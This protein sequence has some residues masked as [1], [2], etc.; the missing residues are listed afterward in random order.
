MK[1]KE[2]AASAAW[3]K[4]SFLP[5][6]RFGAT[7]NFLRRCLF[8]V[9][10]I[11]LL[12]GACGAAS[13]QSTVLRGD[14][15]DPSGAVIPGATMSLTTTDGHTVATATSDASG[16]F[17]VSNLAPG[18]YIVLANAK[19]FA[20]SAFGPSRSP[21]AKAGC[22]TSRS[23]SQSRSSRS[24]SMRTHRPSAS[25]PPATPTVSSSKAKTSTRF[26]MILTGSR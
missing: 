14:V 17:S 20:P 10:G 9:L 24:S 26:P 3:G 16:V 11:A 13:A 25:I 18:T 12:A 8:P 5:H 15:T 23:E 4:A 22:S 21:P 6:K 1:P 2:H 19:G 7:L